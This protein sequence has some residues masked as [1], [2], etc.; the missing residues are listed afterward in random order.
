MASSKG[1]S[2]FAISTRSLRLPI[3]ITQALWIIRKPARA[4]CTLSPAIAMTEAAEAASPRTFTVISP[5][6]SRSRL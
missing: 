2:V 1:F 3:A 6:C 5:S 4:I